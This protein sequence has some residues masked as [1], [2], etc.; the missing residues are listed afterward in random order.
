MS[1][2]KKF[3]CFNPLSPESDE[4]QICPRNIW[5]VIK[6]S[7]NESNII[8]KGMITREEFAWS[9]INCILHWVASYQSSKITED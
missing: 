9:F 6:Q 2:Q 1:I 5:C 4:R 7:G 3:K 8:I